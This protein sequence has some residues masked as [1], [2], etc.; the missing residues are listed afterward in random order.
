MCLFVPL[1]V[2]LSVT[3]FDIRRIQTCEGTMK[4]HLAQVLD[5]PNQYGFLSSNALRIF[6][7]YPSILP[8][9]HIEYA[10]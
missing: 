10:L 3:L 6:A 2:T 4:K 7:L 9:S 1:G 8:S 5:I